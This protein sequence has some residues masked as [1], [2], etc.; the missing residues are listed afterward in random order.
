M[1]ANG[2]LLPRTVLSINLRELVLL[3]DVGKE[4]IPH[5]FRIGAATTAATATYRHG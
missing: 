3:G 2:D 1:L 4:Y 5:S